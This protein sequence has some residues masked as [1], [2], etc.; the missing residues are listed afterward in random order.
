MGW[1]PFEEKNEV[2]PNEPEV[3]NEEKK[4]EKSPAELIA[5]S[6]S[7]FERK[8]TERMDATDAR[9]EA[10]KPTPRP[11]PKPTETPSVYD[12]EDAAFNARLTPLLQHQLELEADIVKE[13]VRREYEGM[14]FGDL[15]AQC[16]KDINQTL[17]NSPLVVQSSQGPAK[18]RGNPDYIRNVADM[19]IGRLARQGG[20]RFNG[21]KKSFFL[22]D[23]TGSAGGNRTEVTDGLTPEQRRVFDRMGVST[24]DRQKAMSKLKFFN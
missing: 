3:K 7:N 23:A 11:D 4:T 18:Q 17:S 19:Y 22:E 5:E 6:F 8:F 16:E 2:K 13:R 12:D 9:V 21:Q 20:V 1:N 10:L 14:G 15:W 24:E